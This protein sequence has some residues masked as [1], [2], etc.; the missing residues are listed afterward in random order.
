MKKLFVFDTIVDIRFKK[1]LK[2]EKEITNLLYNLDD[3]CSIYKST[4]DISKLNRANSYIQVNP[5]VFDILTKS[6]YYSKLTNGYMDITCKSLIDALKNN[7]TPDLSLVNYE[8]IL[9]KN[10]EFVKLAKPGM[11]LDLGS[12]VKGYATDEIVKILKKYNIRNA[13]IN[14]GGNVYVMGHHYLK[15]WRVGIMDPSSPNNIVG[16][17]SLSNK[18]VVTSGIYERGNHIV[19]PHTGKVVD[20]NLTSVSIIASKSLDAEGLST[21]YYIIGLLGLKEIKKFKDMDCIYIDK[22]KNIYLSENIKRKF[23]LTNQ[24]YKIKEYK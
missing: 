8:N 12:I 2:A 9:F 18:S 3:L 17:V 24:D 1:N 13:L 20:N 11:S 19:N 4:S 15:K 22:S 23:I 16:Y 21:A 5:L 10:N 6:I 14:L 7:Q